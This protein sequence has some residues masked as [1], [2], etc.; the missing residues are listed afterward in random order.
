M[1]KIDDTL[2]LS[3]KAFGSLLREK[4][5]IK[6]I[7]LYGSYAEG[8]QDEWSDIDLA[9]IV[10]DIDPHSREIYSIG[11]DFNLDFDA[12]GYSLDDF[13]HSRLPIIPE[14]KRNGIQIL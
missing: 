12:F 13:T 4:Y 14:I 7:Y 1:P 8:K 11:K 3:I 10:D 9:V 5:K 6:N 2:V